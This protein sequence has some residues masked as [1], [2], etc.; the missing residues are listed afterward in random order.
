MSKESL[1]NRWKNLQQPTLPCLICP[2]CGNCANFDAYIPHKHEDMFY[3]G[4][5]V[6]YE[7]LQCDAIFGDLRMLGLSRAEV[8]QDYHD[9]YS[10]YNEGDTTKYMLEIFAKLNFPQ[11]V[12]Y[13]DWA[14]GE[15]NNYIPLLRNS[16]YDIDG[17][18]PFVGDRRERPTRKYD[19]VLSNNFIEH[20]IEP[21]R[22]LAE[23]LS[24]VKD[25]GCLVLISQC[26]KYTITNS[27]YHTFYFLGRSVAW[28]E[29]A[30]GIR[31]VGRQY[32]KFSD[33]MWTIA[34]TFKIGA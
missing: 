14:C 2:V 21:Y 20:V 27:H 18:D 13:L 25:G 34:V 24:F 9:L 15:W 29:K 11:S 32:L 17:Y 26:W 10:F 7:C 12:S 28:L 16:G 5:I 22:D 6:R 30:L 8:A 3:A 4:E 31:E 33:G 19:C 1:I 23:I